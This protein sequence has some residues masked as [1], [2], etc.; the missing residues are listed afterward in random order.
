MINLFVS[1]LKM[2]VRNRQQLFWSLAFPLIF[3]VIFGFFFG[4]GSSSAGT[5]ALVKQSNS[6]V[7]NTLSDGIT[8]TD[9]FKVKTYATEDEARTQLKKNQV[10]AIVVIPTLF[11]EQSANGTTTVNIISN[12]SNAQSNSIINGFISQYLTQINYQI[13]NAKP[14]Y[15]TSTE[16]S[17]SGSFSYFDFVLVGLIGMALMNSSIQ[18]VSITMSKYREDQILKRLTT[19]PLKPWKFIVSEVAARLLVNVIQISLILGIGILGFHAKVGS[20]IPIIMLLSLLGAILFQLIGFSVAASVKTA[21]AA[22]G[23]STAVAIPMMFLAGVFFPIDQLPKWLFSIIQYLPL[24]PLLRLMRGAALE[25]TSIFENPIN[26]AIVSGWIVV[27]LIYSS[28]RFRLTE[29]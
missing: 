17:S 7:A 14:I 12:P 13:Q 10:T 3:T 27:L 11:G 18:G 23:M 20:A 1:N 15:S 8:Q 16:N 5:V 22:E 9:L 4:S 26:I 19:T 2:L 25:S 6:N 28:M 21:D 29:E 24:A